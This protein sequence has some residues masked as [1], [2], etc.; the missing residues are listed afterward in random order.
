[1]GFLMTRPTPGQVAQLQSGNRPAI[2]GAHSVGVEDGGAGLPF[3]GWSTQGGDLRVPHFFGLH[4]L[5]VI[6]LAGL[7]LKRLFRDRLNEN[8]RVALLWTVSMGYL[9][10]VLLVTWQALRGQSIVHPDPLTLIGFGALALGVAGSFGLILA[11]QNRTD[12]PISRPS[13]NT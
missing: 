4:A 10:W 11:S 7:A 3:L 5:Q 9:G 1:M 13:S 12:L 6:P 2:I 8:R